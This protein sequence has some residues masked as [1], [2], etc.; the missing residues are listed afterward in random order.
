MLDLLTYREKRIIHDPQFANTL[1]GDTRFSVL[2]L[3]IRFWLGFQWSAVAA[4]KIGNSAW[5]DG[6]VLRDHW[7]RVMAL[8]EVNTIFNYDWYRN[9]IQYMLDK[10]A[11]TWF[12]NIVVYGELLLGIALIIGAFTGIAA[13]FGIMLHWNFMIIGTTSA[14]PLL[15]IFGIGLMFAWKTAGL[16]GADYFLLNLLGTPWGRD[17]FEEPPERTPARA[18][19][20]D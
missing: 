13:F 20:G 17:D 18:G 16:I 11:Y 10:E 3:I 9:F 15:L 6:E 19:I 14:N 1:F 5:M 4:S 7:L 8:P 2:W 12:A